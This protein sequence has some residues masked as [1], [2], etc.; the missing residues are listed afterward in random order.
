MRDAGN[1]VARLQAHCPNSGVG[2][3]LEKKCILAR[4]RAR[5]PRPGTKCGV[6]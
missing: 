5:V 1:D 2:T 6:T 3:D 4:N